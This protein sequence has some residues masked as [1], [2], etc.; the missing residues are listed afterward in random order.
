MSRGRQNIEVNFVVC[1]DNN[2]S[3]FLSWMSAGHENIMK[4]FLDSS[5][6]LV[7]DHWPSN[8]VG[9]YV[10]WS[11]SALFS[12]LRLS[13]PAEPLLYPMFKFSTQC[14]SSRMGSRNSAADQGLIRS[15][16]LS[17]NMLMSML[18]IVIEDIQDSLGYGL[19]NW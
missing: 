4:M 14:C 19:T 10:P 5:S 3:N 8:Q 16:S 13:S 9:N 11:Q 17:S 15:N 18:I 7:E 6:F 12:L 1:H 2:I